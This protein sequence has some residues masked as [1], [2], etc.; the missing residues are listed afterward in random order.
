MYRPVPEIHL[1]HV[2]HVVAQLGLQQIVG[3]HRVE[4]LARQLDA[5]GG[6]HLEVV[7][8]VLSDFKD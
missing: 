8:Y 4:H 7:L 2:V 6:Q 1:G 3:Y 5:V